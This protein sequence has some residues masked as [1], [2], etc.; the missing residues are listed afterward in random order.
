MPTSDRGS[1]AVGEAAIGH[2]YD[3]L[4]AFSLFLEEG[5]RYRPEAGE[6]P[7]T[8]SEALMATMFEWGF[9]ELWEKGDANSL[10]KALPQLSFLVLVPFMGGDAASE[11]VE[12]KLAPG[13]GR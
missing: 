2:A 3:R 6:L 13:E 9:Q 8:V 12:E 4:S 7:R 1:A 5:Y 10:R 11:F